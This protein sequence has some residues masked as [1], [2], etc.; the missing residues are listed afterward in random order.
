MD[1]SFVKPLILWYN[2]NSRTLPWRGVR[3]PYRIWISEIMLQQTRVE[4]VVDYYLRFIEALPDVY[5]LAECPEDGLLKLW[6]GLGYYSRAR[7]LQKAARV[8]CEQYGG[9]LPKTASELKCLPGIGSYTAGAIASIAF[10]EAEPAVDG[11]VLRVYA[12]LTELEDD[13]MR[14][15]VR[16]RVRDELRAAYPEADGSWGL[17]NQAFMDL[18]SGICRANTRPDCDRCPLSSL[19][20]SHKDRREKDFPIREAKTKRHDEKRTVFL[21]RSGG[22]FALAKRP[23]EGLL[24]NLYEF[25]S[26]GGWLDPD[27][28]KTY[29]ADRGFQILDVKPLPESKHVFSH[30][31]WRM[32]AYAVDI[33]SRGSFRNW[34][35]VKPCDIQ[36]QFPVPSAFARY[37]AYLN[38]TG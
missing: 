1:S 33:A 32:C 18:G 20:L 29:F 38:E 22:R 24:A 37:L 27:E 11:N 26:C 35:F 4:S 6:E 34:I 30:L 28:V 23:P 2:E 5:A 31:T 15:A 21:I 8:L 25:P 9:Q 13:I 17:L 10:G 12:R 7:N 3:D 14:D 36:K 19:C 16:K